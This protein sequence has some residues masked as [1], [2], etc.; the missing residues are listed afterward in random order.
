MKYWISSLI[1][2]VLLFSLF[3]RD[4][5]Y[6]DKVINY[7]GTNLMVSID[8]VS[9]N[10]LPSEGTYYLTRYKCGNSGTK[11]EW[12]NSSY[13]L[14]IT[15]GSSVG[16]IACNLTF[17]SKPRLSLMS[18]GSYVKYI[19]N[20]GCMG[21][22]CYGY[23]ANYKNDDDMGYC[24]SADNKY[25]TNGYRIFYVDNDSVYL[26]SAGALECVKRSDSSTNSLLYLN[27]LN[28]RALNYCNKEFA[29][30]GECNNNSVRSISD[31]DY[32]KY[33]DMN[34]YDCLNN[35]SNKFC[36]YNNDLIDNGGYYWFSSNYDSAGNKI[37]SWDPV[38]RV[39]KSDT[40]VKDYGLRVVIRLKDSVYVV[41]GDGSYDSPYVIA[42][43]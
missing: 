10:K 43:K 4:N 42:V 7:N 18:S 14:N 8:G 39:I 9:S 6:S 25:I 26:V 27:E 1:L 29:Y 23:N 2:F 19:G 37:F 31:F 15:N 20:N 17:E 13:E 24:F 35:S 21:N 16:G 40:Y 12:D 28:A 22:S 41:S 38:G 3:Y 5:N 34:I 30:N 33:L 32:D 11:I 36:G